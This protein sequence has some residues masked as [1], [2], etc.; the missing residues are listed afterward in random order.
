MA[1]K[2]VVCC[3]GTWNKADQEFPTNVM[4]FHS[5]LIQDG[6]QV[7]EYVRGVGSGDNRIKK[8]LAGAF[9]VGVSDRVREAYLDVAR[10]YTEQAKPGEASEKDE[11]FLLGFSRGAFTARSVAGMIHNVGI[12][13]PEL[14][15]DE[16]VVDEAFAIYRS[17]RRASRKPRGDV[18]VKFKRDNTWGVE[19]A[20][21]FVGVWDTV[22]ALGIPLG[23]RSL[24][25][26][27]R[28][29]RFHDS[30]LNGGVKFA[31]H[32]LALDERRRP[33]T[34]TLWTW[35]AGEKPAPGQ[36][37]EQVWFSGVHSDVGGGYED[38]GLS[39]ITL[40][41]MADRAAAQGVKFDK[42]TLGAPSGCGAVTVNQVSFA[43]HPRPRTKVIH[44]SMTWWYA[45][46][47]QLVRVPDPEGSGDLTRE[48]S[49]NTESV[50][51]SA[52]TRLRWVK[53]YAAGATNLVSLLA[54][55]SY[56]WASKDTTICGHPSLDEAA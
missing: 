24:N 14:I 32:A 31:Y 27:S 1:K 42:G 56:R 30:Q 22:G 13:R 21:H 26:F 25:F 12:I 49:R 53:K 48:G 9:G 15:T 47:G 50:S 8:L 34:P 28:R 39:D 37:V 36:T 51:T 55:P 20:V 10:H 44:S 18:A 4:R 33:F 29:N 3:D 54:R 45:L 41:W 2:I 16:R 23:L 40:Q 7:A 46:L 38:T 6:G 52:K 35:K 43:V 17:R 5:A 19:P 11:I